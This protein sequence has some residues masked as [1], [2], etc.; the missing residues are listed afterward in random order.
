A[1]GNF[2]GSIP[3]G[4]LAAGDPITATATD[5]AGSTSEFATNAPATRPSSSTVITASSNPSVYGQSLSLTATVTGPS[6]APTG[7]VTFLDGTT[8][9]GTVALGGGTATFTTSSLRAGVHGITA[10][11]GGDGL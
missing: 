2:R 10:I 3:L 1:G 4:G 9:L 5:T 11:Y 6:G 8:V 7:T